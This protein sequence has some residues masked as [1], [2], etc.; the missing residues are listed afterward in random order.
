MKLRITTL[1]TYAAGLVRSYGKRKIFCVGL[2]KTGT[3]SLSKALENLGIATAPQRPAE[4]LLHDW[5][6]RDFRGIIRFCKYFQAFQDVPFSCPFTY[7]ALDAAFPG[8]K[9]ILTIRA[10]P[11]Q[12]AQSL[13]RFHS[14]LFARGR[15]PRVEDLQR[16]EYC[17]PGFA[18][19]FYR[20]VFGEA[21]EPLYDLQMLCGFY[22]FHYTSVMEYFRSRPADLLV[23]DVARD[24]ALSDLCRFLGKPLLNQPFPFCN[25]TDD[26]AV[27]APGCSKVSRAS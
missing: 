22:Q 26:I 5:A 6:R 15:L 13:T 2:N 23:L 9:F 11:E 8:S 24:T 10:N 14:K 20:A 19:D 7:Q 21:C 4:L 18:L 1:R 12:W 16:A 25:K 17:Y 27:A 3:T